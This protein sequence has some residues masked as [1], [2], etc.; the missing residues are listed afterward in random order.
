MFTWEQQSEMKVSHRH[1]RCFRRRLCFSLESMPEIQGSSLSS[2]FIVLHCWLKF[3]LL[4]LVVLLKSNKWAGSTPWERPLWLVALK[5]ILEVL[6]QVQP[7]H[8]YDLKTTTLL[9]FLSPHR[10][11]V[12]GA[13]PGLGSVCVEFSCC[14]C[15]SMQG[16]LG[17]L[18][19]SQVSVRHGCLPI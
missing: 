1:P 11:M 15:V 13:I 9:L 5:G 8:L 4:S 6:S 16:E 7:K 17:T 14:P 3:S 12:E 19:F 18:Q 10:K 2:G